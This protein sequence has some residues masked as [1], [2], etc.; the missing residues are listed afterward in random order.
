M[1]AKSSAWSAGGTLNKWLY[2]LPRSDLPRNSLLHSTPA[3]DTKK[4]A[5]SRYDWYGNPVEPL[6]IGGYNI[7]LIH[8]SWDSEV[9]GRQS[10][11]KATVR[12]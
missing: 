8:D 11:I 3:S 9:V 4:L 2:V 10:D 1:N 7:S 12:A 6:K 5:R